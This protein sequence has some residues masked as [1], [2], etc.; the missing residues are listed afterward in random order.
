MTEN[1]QS[2]DVGSRWLSRAALMFV[3]LA[4]VMG[5]AASFVGL[6]DYGL[7]QM[8]G[9]TNVTAW[10]IPGAFDGAAFGTSLIT[11]RASINGRSA[12]RG[13]LLMWA[14]TAV[15]SG[16]NYIHQP[17]HTAQLVAAGLPMAAVAVFDV[18]LLELRADYEARH[19]KRGFRLRPGL[20]MLRWIVDRSGTRDAFRSQV[21]A[22]P[23]EEIAGLGNPL[24]PMHA[25]AVGPKPANVAS[26][27]ESIVDAEAGELVGAPEPAE[28]VTEAENLEEDGPVTPTDSTDGS[29]SETNGSLKADDIP[30]D[31]IPADGTP[32]DGT[33]ADDNAADEEA[34]ASAESTDDS[35]EQGDSREQGDSDDHGDSSEHVESASAPSDR[36]K[37]DAMDSELQPSSEHIDDDTQQ[38]PVTTDEQTVTP[39]PVPVRRMTDA[40]KR[41]AAR[42]DYLVSLET[43]KPV[44]GAQLGARYGYSARWG[45]EQIKA[46]RKQRQREQRPE[47]VGAGKEN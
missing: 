31:D 39:P 30:A 46:A 3:A 21:M 27:M 10:F 12:L 18:V 33:P 13:R 6:Q 29:P 9:F 15:S 16:I 4:A 45:R 37:A 44:N 8:N 42:R 41:A 38:I 36:D 2:V 17:D 5:W 14:F 34:A 32:A 43:E 47:L 22:I 7:H 40:D 28:T 11:Y 26:P 35:H 25:N 19:G 23:V 1:A 24:L 20:L